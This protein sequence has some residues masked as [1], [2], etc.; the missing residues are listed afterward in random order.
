MAGLIPEAAAIAEVAA[1]VAAG[2]CQG[3]CP[4]RSGA[5]RLLSEAAAHPQ[6]PWEELPVIQGAIRPSMV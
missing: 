4:F 2:S 6:S 5:I 1:E 3:R